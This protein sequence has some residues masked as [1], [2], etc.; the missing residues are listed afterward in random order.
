MLPPINI[1]LTGY[2]VEEK[3]VAESGK[4]AGRVYLPITWVGKRVAVVLLEPFDE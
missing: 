2:G 1:T 3:K 4:T